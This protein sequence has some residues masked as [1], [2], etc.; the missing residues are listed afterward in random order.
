MII[1]THLSLSESSSFIVS[2]LAPPTPTMMMDM[3]REEAAMMARLVFDMSDITP[4]V[5]ISRIKYCYRICGG[6]GHGH[7][8]SINCTG[9]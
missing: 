9:M 1:L 6:R 4:S 5:S 8:I 2:N 7:M 3:G